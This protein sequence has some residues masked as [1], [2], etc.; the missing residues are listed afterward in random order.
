MSQL[1]NNR[2]TFYLSEIGGF[3]FEF[4]Y[5]KILDISIGAIDKRKLIHT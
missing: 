3:S 5:S 2:K 1:K 4:C